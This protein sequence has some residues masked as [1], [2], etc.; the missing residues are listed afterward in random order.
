ML[1]RAYRPFASMMMLAGIALWVGCRPQ[2]GP[3][4][5]SH[6]QTPPLPDSEIGQVVQ[7]Y[8]DVF[9]SGDSQ[10]LDQFLH[11][12]L[13]EKGP[14]G[15]NIESRIRTVEAEI[16]DIEDKMAKG[17]ID[18]RDG[19]RSIRRKRD[20]IRDYNRD[21]GRAEADLGEVQRRIEYFQRNP[22]PD[23]LYN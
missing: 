3:P 23:G 2:H 18:Q 10:R 6:W 8:V 5:E 14:G 1:K 9:N 13:S 19:E 11:R 7:E 16:D 20:D 17:K 15:A 21:L 4:A 12:H 22:R